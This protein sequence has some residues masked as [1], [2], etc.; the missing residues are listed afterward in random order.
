MTLHLQAFA[1]SCIHLGR[2]S[3]RPPSQ[4]ATP[5]GGVG[6]WSSQ[7]LPQ[8]RFTG[9]RIYSA[10]PLGP[11]SRPHS[12]PVTLPCACEARFGGT[13]QQV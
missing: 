13:S 11:T 8:P 6:G 3:W 12:R 10:R 1:L 9:D 2:R 5:A 4:V 7:H